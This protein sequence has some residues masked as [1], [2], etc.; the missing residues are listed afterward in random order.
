MRETHTAAFLH[1]EGQFGG[2]WMVNTDVLGVQFWRVDDPSSPEL[3]S[4]LELPGVTFIIGSYPRTVHSVSWQ[5][6]YLYVAAADNGVFVVDAQDP[7][8]PLMV[9]QFTFDP[10]LRAGFVYAMGSTL[11]VGGS[12]ER[13]AALIDISVPIEPQPIPGGRFDL[14]DAVPA[15]R[16]LTPCSR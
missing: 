6:P 15:S 10:P 13:Q 1:L 3:I 4:R 5:Y 7:N 2:D 8:N 9:N 14:L 16:V 11:F 12:E